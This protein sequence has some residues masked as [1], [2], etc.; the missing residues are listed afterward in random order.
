MFFSISSMVGN[1]DFTSANSFSVSYWAIPKGWVVP[2]RAYWAF[3][4]LFSRQSNNPIVGLS[5][6]AYTVSS[7]AEI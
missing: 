7:I 4:L 2:R 3:T 1:D 5:T 6:E